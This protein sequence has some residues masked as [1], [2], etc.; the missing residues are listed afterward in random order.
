MP[1]IRIQ[2]HLVEYLHSTAFLP[3][4]DINLECDTPLGSMAAACRLVVLAHEKHMH[5][6][7][8]CDDHHRVG[9]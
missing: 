8:D 6:G 4:V 2:S 1:E 7:R 5:V 9:E 3:V